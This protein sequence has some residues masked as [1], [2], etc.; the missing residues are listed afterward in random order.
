MSE[1]HLIVLDGY[2]VIHRSRDLRPGPERTL[3]EA[4]HKLI[5]LLSWTVGGGEARFLIVFDGAEGGGSA[6]TGSERVQVRWSRPPTKADDVIRDIVEAEI[7]RG[8]RVTVA[9]ADLEV[10]R[11]ARAMGAN[12]VLSELFLASVLGPQRVEGAEKPD[13]PNRRELEE[14]VEL[15]RRR[16]ED[17]SGEPGGD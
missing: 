17:P 12:V 5:A 4:R 15:F 6:H 14:W 1:E 9:T 8:R 16:G 2:N 13:A 3:E 11:H 10:A 7:E